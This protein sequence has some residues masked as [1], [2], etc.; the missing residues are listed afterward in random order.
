MCAETGYRGRVALHEMM[1]VSD[2]I[3]GLIVSGASTLDLRRAAES[4]GMR[5]LRDDG[6]VK[7]RDGV[8]TALEVLRVA[9]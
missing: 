5:S 8:T 4:E 6:F 9:R 1:A 7:A 3:E 2:D